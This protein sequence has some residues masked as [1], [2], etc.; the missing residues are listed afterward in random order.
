MIRYLKCE[1]DNTP[2][3]SASVRV[4]YHLRIIMNEKY[5]VG[6]KLMHDGVKGVVI[7][8]FSPVPSY[9]C[10][11]WETGFKSTYDDWALDEDCEILQ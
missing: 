3:T 7:E 2:H 6:T 11:E 1:I 4:G 8:S 9:I 10:V 5:S